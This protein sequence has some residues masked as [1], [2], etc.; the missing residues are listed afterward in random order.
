MGK[1]DELN[2]QEFGSLPLHFTVCLERLSEYPHCCSLVWFNVS[3]VPSLLVN[4][5]IWEFLPLT[6]VFKASVAGEKV[7][8]RYSSSCERKDRGALF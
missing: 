6:F 1:V 4:S 3:G 7:I 5:A 2:S 8:N